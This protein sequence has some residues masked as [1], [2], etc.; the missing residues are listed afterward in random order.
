MDK[1]NILLF[2]KKVNFNFWQSYKWR[3][4]WS[5]QCQKPAD[6]WVRD[7]ARDCKILQG[8]VLHII[9]L[10][11]RLSQ[12]LA[13]GVYSLPNKPWFLHVCSICLLKTRWEKEKLLIT[14]NFSFSQCFLPIWKTLLFSSKVK[15]SSAD[16]FSLGQSKIYRLGKG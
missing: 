8:T 5:Q 4:Q 3:E 2:G 6:W 1:S 10:E 13:K 12:F 16:S 7:C 14:S 11:I 9:L 15:M